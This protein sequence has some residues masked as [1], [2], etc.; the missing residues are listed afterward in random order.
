[1]DDDDASVTGQSTWYADDDGDGYGDS[2]DS[3]LACTQ[4]STHVSDATDCDDGDAA[5]NPAASEICDSIDNDCDGDIDDDDAS[6]T[7]QSTWYADGDGDGY[8]DS[9][10]STLACTQPSTHVA[11]STD[12]DDGDATVNP[13]ASEI[14]DTV[15]NDCDGDVD[16]DDASVTG[17]SSWYA[18]DDGDGYGDASDSTDACFQPTGSVADATD[19]DDSDASINPVGTEICDTV[20]NDCDGDVDDDDASVT[21]QSTWYLDGDGDGYGLDTATLAACTQPSGY[22]AL[23]G[24]CDDGDAAYNPGAA[25]TDCADPADYNCDG[26][27]GYADD[28]ADGWAACEECDD[29]DAAIHPAATEIC[30]TVDN[31]CD[32]DIDDDDADITGQSSWYTDD[33]GDGYGDADD[34]TDACFEP[35]GRVSDATD[36]DDGDATIHPAATEICDTVDNDCDGDIDDDDASVTGQSTW[37]LDGDGDGF[38][39]DGTALEACTQPSGHAAQGG[40][41]DDGDV[42]YHPGADESDC[43]DPADYNCDGSTGYA[44]E[45]DDGWAACEECDDGD[46]A[47][48]PGATELC[49]GVDNDCDGHTDEDDAADAASWYADTDGDGYTDEDDS[50][51][52]CEAPEGYTEASVDPD[53]DD[54]DAAVNPGATELCDSIDNDCDGHTDEDDAAD[55]ASWY[56]D[57]DGDGYT[58]EDDSLTACEA[59]EGYSEASAEPDCDDGEASVY[60]GA[61]EIPGDGIDQDCD[62]EDLLSDTGDGSLDDTDIGGGKQGCEGCASGGPAGGTGWLLLGLVPLGLVRRRRAAHPKRRG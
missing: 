18:D 17:Q 49:D 57:T 14:C 54:G 25:E 46:A 37:Y 1:M 62:G 4:P 39:L 38:G 28:D 7:G 56:A 12:C 6:V 52:A 8:G 11:D 21:G 3:T 13:A 59:P 36:C 48:N 20:D 50:Q 34:S 16:D 22:A 19:C 30:D 31:D 60:P 2:G 32:G 23:G 58:D 44:D 41:C 43:T 27:T 35:V 61:V 15:D 29:T 42:A 10:D 24:D 45:D 53:C 47:V 26:S 55:A 40:D 51:T 5:V 9:G 33:D